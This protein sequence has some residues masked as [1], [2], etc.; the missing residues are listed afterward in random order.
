MRNPDLIH[1]DD[2]THHPSDFTSWTFLFSVPRF[3]GSDDLLH[4]ASSLPAVD[5][6]PLVDEDEKS[7]A[8]L[9]L[10]HDCGSLWDGSDNGEADDSASNE[11]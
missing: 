2:E 9:D 8:S 6:S 5:H 1:P 10:S 11:K 3:S 4:H 7:T